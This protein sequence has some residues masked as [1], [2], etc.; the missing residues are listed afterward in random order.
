MYECMNMDHI[1]NANNTRWKYSL[2]HIKSTEL[3]YKIM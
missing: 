2:I 3:Y 1:L